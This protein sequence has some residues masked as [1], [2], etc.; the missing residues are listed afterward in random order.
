MRHQ[1]Q[2]K[3]DSRYCAKSCARHFAHARRKFYDV[4]VVDCSPIATEAIQ[5][6]GALYAI[7]RE[8]RGSVSAQR[9]RVR[10]QRAGPLLDELHAWLSTTLQKVSVKS[11]LAGAIKYALVRWTALTR[12]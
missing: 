5:R 6:I 8:I 3:R 4:Y 12:Y 2:I 7:E 10:Q 9:A 1:L 11:E